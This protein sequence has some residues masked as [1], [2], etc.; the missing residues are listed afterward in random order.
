MLNILKGR[1][2][3]EFPFDPEFGVNLVI[4]ESKLEESLFVNAVD[5]ELIKTVV[6]Y[7]HDTVAQVS[8]R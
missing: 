3:K 6:L 5:S 2:S 4:V 1:E 7:L 8:W